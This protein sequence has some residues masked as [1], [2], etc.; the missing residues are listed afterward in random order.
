[1][2]SIDKLNEYCITCIVSDCIFKDDAEQFA[3]NCPADP[4]V[5]SPHYQRLTPGN[6]DKA[7]GE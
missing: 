7:A 1:M 6:A 4:T 5:P 2:Y 3:I